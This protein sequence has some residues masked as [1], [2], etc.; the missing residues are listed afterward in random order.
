MPSPNRHPHPYIYPHTTPNSRSYFY[1]P[2]CYPSTHHCS[3]GNRHPPT[4][5]GIY[6][7]ANPRSL[8]PSSYRHSHAANRIARG[9]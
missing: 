1:S 7:T 3:P 9:R 2:Y 6:S 5:N 8:S 4:N